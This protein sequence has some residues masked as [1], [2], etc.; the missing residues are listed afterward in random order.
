[1]HEG[2]DLLRRGRQADEI[3]SDAADERLAAGGW[4]RLQPGV[5]QLRHDEAINGM[6]HTRAFVLDLRRLR[7]LHRPEGPVPAISVCYGKFRTGCRLCG[8]RDHLAER[9][10]IGRTR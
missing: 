7:S 8:G 2:A 4:R 10:A 6:R 3:E 5:L 9:T 1:M